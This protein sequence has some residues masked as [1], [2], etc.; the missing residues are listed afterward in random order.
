MMSYGIAKAT[1]SY[2]IEDW[3]LPEPM[4]TQFTDIYVS[5]GHQE[6]TVQ[7]VNQIKSNN[8]WAPIY[9]DG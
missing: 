8:L 4:M 7:I 5:L 6:L 3:T 9:Q 1:M 2:H